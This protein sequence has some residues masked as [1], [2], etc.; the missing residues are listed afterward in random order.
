L[1][2]E[3]RLAPELLLNVCDGFMPLT[4]K[5]KFEEDEEVDSNA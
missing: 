1:H 3:S 5:K 2:T 4:K